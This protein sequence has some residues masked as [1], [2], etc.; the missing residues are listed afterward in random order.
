MIL[1]EDLKQKGFHVTV[2]DIG[3][4]YAADY[5][6]G[7]SPSAAD[8]AK[9]IVPLLGDFHRNGG[10]IILEPGRSIAGN[11]GILL[12]RVLYIKFGGKKKFVI[13]D[14]GMSNLIRVAMYD[15]F[16]GPSPCTSQQ[17]PTHGDGRVRAV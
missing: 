14:A 6:T 16:H 9:D 3:G 15:S 12:T 11:A 2:L 13:I 8:Y 17:I 1:I 4:G 10:K 7:R 5:E